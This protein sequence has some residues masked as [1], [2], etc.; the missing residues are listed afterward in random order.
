MLPALDRKSN[1]PAPYPT[2]LTAK[3]KLLTSS[4]Q[5]RT[6]RATQLA[7][8]AALNYVSAYSFAHRKTSSGKRLQKGTYADLRSQFGLPA[9]MACNV[10]RQ[11]GATYQGLWTKARK[12]AEA[13]RL[14]YTRR[15]GVSLDK[16]PHYVSPTLTYNLGRDYSLRTGQQVSILSLGGRI[17]VP[18]QG[19]RH[20]V[21]RLAGGSHH[22]RSQALV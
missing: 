3:L 1:S 19:Y 20:H 10:P 6:L 8:R 18:Y 16:A 5:F 4:D 21:A 15:R 7:Y 13:R 12:N 17:H 2:T 14:G 22:R 9:Q 11:V